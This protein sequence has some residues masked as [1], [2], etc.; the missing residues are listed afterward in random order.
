MKNFNADLN[1]VINAIKKASVGISRDFYEIEKLQISKKGVADFV[2]NADLK[3]EKTLVATLQKARPQYSFLTEES[4][5][6]QSIEPQNRDIE[7]KWVI[8]PI[9]GTFNFMHGLPFFCISIALVKIEQNKKSVLLGAV[10]N[11][12]NNEIFWAG[13]NEGA[14]LLDQMGGR[15]KMIVSKHNNFEKMICG[16]N[17]CNIAY[18]Q[19]SCSGKNKYLEYVQQKNAHIRMFGASALEM[20]YLADG[21]INLLVQD[22][23]KAWDYAAGLLLIKEAGGVVKDLSGNDF[24]FDTDDGSI[25]GNIETVMEIEKNSKGV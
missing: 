7:Y 11:P 23:M 6:I 3:A 13:R 4:G 12:I 20:A 10:S 5:E 14:Y 15:R 22:K 1:V 25:A 24:E 9:D 18:Y 16:I 8:D 17:Y 19:M 2:T 21:R